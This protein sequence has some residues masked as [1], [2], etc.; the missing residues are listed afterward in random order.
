M[1]FFFFGFTEF[2]SNQW[3]PISPLLTLSF[4]RV[5]IEF[6]G[7]RVK[8]MEEFKGKTPKIRNLPGFKFWLHHYGLGYLGQVT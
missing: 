3:V 1:G 8:T 7:R 5:K 6:N 4:P 2:F